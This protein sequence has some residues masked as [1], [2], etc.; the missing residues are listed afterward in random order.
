MT[1]D[2]SGLI[3]LNKQPGIS[4]FDALRDIKRALGTGKV[5]HTGTLDK[6]ARG[7]MLVLTGRALKLSQWFSG[8]DKQ[9]EAEVYFGIE[10]DTLDPTG[11]EV[12]RA[13]VPA[14]NVIQRLL[15]QF[16]GSIAQTPP[17]YS[18][19]HINGKRASALV[20]SGQIPDMK[21]RQISVYRLILSDW[22]PP[23]ARFFIHCSSGTYIRSLAR[24]IA[25]AAGS[26]A[27]VSSLVRTR[28][29][30]FEL[31]TC[32]RGSASLFPDILPIDKPLFCSLG[33]PWFEISEKEIPCI[34]SGK[35]LSNILTD[36]ELIS[37]NGRSNRAAGI[38]C[39]NTLIAVVEK[40]GNNWKYGYVYAHS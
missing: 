8:C 3:L 6:F 4:S 13:E 7:L 9:Y 29:A 40:A 17:V 14:E 2:R 27:H 5:G 24:D 11:L 20:R 15:P 22:S 36:R 34:I 10:T 21:Q 35:P 23:Y 37:N 38:F 16:T 39:D 19:I 12:A 25:R 32:L 1:T 26:C 28:V 33:L 30:G 18:A 31:E